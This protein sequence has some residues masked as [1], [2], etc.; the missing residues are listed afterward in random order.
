MNFNLQTDITFLVLKAD[1]QESSGI[2]YSR[3]V[4]FHAESCWPLSGQAVL[5]RRA[6]SCSNGKQGDARLV[7]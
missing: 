7:R 4:D 1:V 3:E 6:V 5:I 2:L